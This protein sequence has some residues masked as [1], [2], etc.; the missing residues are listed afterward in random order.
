MMCYADP[1]ST[2]YDANSR[3]AVPSTLADTEHLSV[4]PD[5]ASASRTRPEI[6][7]Q[8]HVTRPW[9][10]DWTQFENLGPYGSETTHPAATP[11]GLPLCER[12]PE[13]LPPLSK[14][15]ALKRF[16]R[17]GREMSSRACSWPRS[18]GA[19]T[20]ACRRARSIRH[21]HHLPHGHPPPDDT[22]ESAIHHIH[23]FCF[24][25][26]EHHRPALTA[27]R[28]VSFKAGGR[29]KRRKL[30]ETHPASRTSDSVAGISSLRAVADTTAAP[31]TQVAG[32]DPSSPSAVCIQQLHPLPQQPFIAWLRSRA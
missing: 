5:D 28:F 14:E 31:D 6:W 7:H 23:P 9:S 19:P 17:F 21:E 15:D 29:G 10:F 11:L 12:P 27:T 22:S 2:P 16:A 24:R 8:S 20:F 26:A 32:T 1:V 13:M 30:T 4:S 18:S 25:S 3:P